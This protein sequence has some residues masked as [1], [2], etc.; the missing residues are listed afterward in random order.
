M[1]QL[2]KP[3][4]CLHITDRQSSLDHGQLGEVYNLLRVP[5]EFAENKDADWKDNEI[6]NGFTPCILTSTDLLKHY[7]GIFYLTKSNLK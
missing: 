4:Y 7:L 5:Y 6:T 2:Y 1:C 3:I